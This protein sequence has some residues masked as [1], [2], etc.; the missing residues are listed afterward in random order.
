MKAMVK[1]MLVVAL[2]GNAGLA[3]SI[4]AC[5]RW[6]CGTNSPLVDGAGIAAAG[7]SKAAPVGTSRSNGLPSRVARPGTPVWGNNLNSPV[8]AGAL[9][10]AA[11]VRPRAVLRVVT[12]R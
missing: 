3:H 8:V 10:L 1:T 2:L 11:P 9:I 5:G 4:G 12:A 6:G 7:A